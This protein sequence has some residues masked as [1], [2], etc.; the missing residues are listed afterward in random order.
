MSRKTLREVFVELGLQ[1]EYLDPFS[2]N[3]CAN[4]EAI[5]ANIKHLTAF[6]RLT[7]SPVLSCV[8]TAYPPSNGKPNG[9]TVPLHGTPDMNKPAFS[10]LHNKTII[11]CDN[12]LCVPLDVFS[13]YQQVVL[14]KTHYDPFTNPKLDRL[15]TELPARRFVVYGLPLE[16]SL[17]ILVLGLIRRGRRVALIQDAC[18]YYSQSEAAMTLRQLSV[19]DCKLLTTREFITSTGPHHSRHRVRRRAS[20]RSVA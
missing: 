19:K 16:T 6:A 3:C 17:R 13:K 1:R 2:P 15:L 7:G 8:D 5:R 14:G 18:G 10:L 11:E 12:H 4:A 9:L 20:G